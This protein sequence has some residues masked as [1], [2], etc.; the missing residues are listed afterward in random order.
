[1]QAVPTEKKTLVIE[2][3]TVGKLESA[4]DV[5]AEHRIE[6]DDSVYQQIFEQLK[7]NLR[8]KRTQGDVR[9]ANRL[10][11]RINALET[12][13]DYGLDP[14]KLFPRVDLPEG[15]HGKILLASVSGGMADGLICLR[16]GDDWHNEI[17]RNT[18]EEIRDLGFENSIVVPAGGASVQFDQKGG[19]V[20]YGSSDAFGTCDKQIA[21]GLIR[22]AFSQKKVSI[23]K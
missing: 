17:L 11:R 20:V 1:M 21:A 2:L 8:R 9:A 15:Y 23:R 22:K 3:L 12:F 19:I 7:Q 10:K 16:S 14:E 4:Q 18:Q 5:M 6:L 13:Q